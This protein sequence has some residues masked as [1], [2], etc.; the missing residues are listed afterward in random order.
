MLNKLKEYILQILISIDQLFNAILGGMAD[1]TLSSRAWRA[2]KSNKVFG[3]IFRPLIDT[4]MFFDKN[5]CFGSYLSE[6]SR[7]QLPLHFR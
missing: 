2:E 5:H 1:E 7:R 6:I 3:K 4:L